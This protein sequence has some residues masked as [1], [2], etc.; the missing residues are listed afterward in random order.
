[1]RTATKKAGIVKWVDGSPVVSFPYAGRRI[2]RHVSRITSNGDGN[3]KLRKNGLSGEFATVGVALSPHK[4][5]GIGNLCTDASDAC[6]DGCLNNTGLGAVFASIQHARIAKTIAY[7]RA[8]QWFLSTLFHE[9]LVARRRAIANGKHLAMRPNVFSDIIWEDVYPSMFSQFNDVQF[10]DYTKHANRTGLVLPN[11]WVTFSRS[12]TNH[13][14]CL[15]V[16]SR[17][18]N[19]AVVFDP[20]M[21][22]SQLCKLKTDDRPKLPRSWNG[23]DV[24]AGD[25]SDLRFDDLR[26]RTRGKVVG[27]LLKSATHQQRIDAVESGFALRIRG[28]T[29]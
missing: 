3:T 20:G 15:R 7:Y 18:H 10:Y 27:L 12:E 1:M 5:G 29:T 8:R 2:I 13:D 23:F 16:L 11:Y 6:V 9:V 21:T 17:G 19:V 22:S 25:D 4:S 24:I 14:D 28:R 26:G